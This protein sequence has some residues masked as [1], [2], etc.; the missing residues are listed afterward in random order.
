MWD[1]I[2]EFS[3]WNFI[4]DTNWTFSGAHETVHGFC[5]LQKMDIIFTQ[6]SAQTGWQSL[7]GCKS[8]GRSRVALNCV[9]VLGAQNGHILVNTRRYMLPVG[10]NR[11]NKIQHRR[12]HK[13]YRN[14]I[15]HAKLIDVPVTTLKCVIYISKNG[16]TGLTHPQLDD[17]S[18]EGH[19]R[20]Q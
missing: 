13:P 5:W 7:H 12:L 15:S 6:T 9:I 2:R 14:R 17:F 18:K 19:H 20:D 11:C 16:K 4:R 1:F 10:R 3:L 8:C